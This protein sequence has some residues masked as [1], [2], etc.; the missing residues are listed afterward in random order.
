MRGNSLVTLIILVA[1]AVIAVLAVRN[2]VLAN[3]LL[4]VQLAHYNSI[5]HV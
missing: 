1:L 2:L 4:K 3:Q 5:P